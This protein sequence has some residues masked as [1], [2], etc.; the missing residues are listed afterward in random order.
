[1]IAQEEKATKWRHFCVASVDIETSSTQTNDHYNNVG[2]DEDQE[3][4]MLEH[5]GDY[6][7]I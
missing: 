5:E 3:E 4:N 6:V 1:M 7:K 2:G